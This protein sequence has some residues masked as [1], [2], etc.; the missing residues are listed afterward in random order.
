MELSEFLRLYPL[1]SPGLMWL[2]GAGCSLSGGIQTATDMILDFKRL[3][4]CS[5]LRK[6]L[7]C[8]PHRSDGVFRRQ[9]ESHFASKMDFP[10]SGSDEEYSFY[11]EYT[12]PNERERRKYIEQMIMNGRPSLGH[13]AIAALV[14]SGHVNRLWTTNFDRLIEDS[15]CAATGSSRDLAIVT[16]DNAHL[17]KE[18]E[19]ERG[20]KAV[21]KLHGDFQS[22]RLKNTSDEL[23]EQDSLL[24]SFLKKECG[25]LGL[26]V[27]GYSGRDSSILNIFK[28]VLKEH[29]REAFPNGF[30]W[31]HRSGSPPSEPIVELLQGLKDAGVDAHFV[32]TETF[33]E[34]MRDILAMYPDSPRE[35]VD[36]PGNRTRR[37]IKS[38]I[39]PAGVGWPVIRLNAVPIL[40]YPSI[41]RRVV[42]DLTR[43]KDVRDAIEATNAAVVGMK[44]SDSIIC[45]GADHEVRKAFG[46]GN[47][48]EFDVY[49]IERGRLEFDSAE[50][51]LLSE[52][53]CLGLSRERG[54]SVYRAFGNWLLAANKD[55]SNLATSVVNRRIGSVGGI[56]PGTSRRWWEAVRIKLQS[57]LN[58]LFLVFEPCEWMEREVSG[59]AADAGRSLMYGEDAEAVE[60]FKRE[61]AA[62]RYNKQLIAYL[63]TWSEVLS[64]CQK[65]FGAVSTFGIGDG[66]DAK[67]LISRTTAFSRRL[68]S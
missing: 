39:P 11:F 41:C 19:R 8:L 44:R 10:K 5:E 28:M 65:D 34:L 45:F 57:R 20:R 30:F 64:G 67:F 51:A 1:R 56:V 42:C 16:L 31:M 36:D 47:I 25:S 37:A 61:R 58:R 50:L 14:A 55:S 66:I 62:K 49:P 21:I 6:P 13:R 40:E 38:S 63:D 29:G 4:Y 43:T 53:L 23:K 24:R 59:N 35:I 12:Y 52:S 54:L 15:I 9:L 48:R 27:C 3:L 60:T 32:E 2:L 33:D 46:S 18:L 7:Q 26:A 22:S 68:T 17:V